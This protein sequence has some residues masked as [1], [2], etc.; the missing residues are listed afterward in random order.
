MWSNDEEDVVAGSTLGW[1]RS[2]TLAKFGLGN[3]S[4][5]ADQFKFPFALLMDTQLALTHYG[6]KFRFGLVEET[7]FVGVWAALETLQ[8][9]GKIRH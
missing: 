5:A 4:R 9:G 3:T 8:E 6:L 2:R 1:F 7:L